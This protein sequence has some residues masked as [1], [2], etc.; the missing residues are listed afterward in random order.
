[1]SYFSFDEAYAV[2]QEHNSGDPITEI[3]TV[4]Y[5]NLYIYHGIDY[6]T[7]CKLYNINNKNFVIY[8]I[9]VCANFNKFNIKQIY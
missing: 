2:L 5:S 3:E 4:N 7:V 6:E 9:F 1:M 8:D